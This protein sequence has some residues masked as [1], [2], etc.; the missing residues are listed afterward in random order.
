MHAVRDRPVMVAETGSDGTYSMA[1]NRSGWH[2]MVV[3]GRVGGAP[4]PGEYFG[5]YEG[6]VG[7]AVR[8]K[9]NGAVIADIVASRVMVDDE[10]ASSRPAKAALT[11]GMLRDVVICKSTTWAGKI[12]ISGVVVVG[13]EATLTILPGTTVSFERLDR[14]GDGI[15][16]GEL[17][18]LGR[19]LVRGDAGSPVR[20]T[21][22][23]SRARPSDWSYVLLFAARQKSVVEHA[24]FENAF[25]GLQ[26]HFSSVAIRDSV[27][28]RNV[29]GI[30]FGRARIIIAHNRIAKNRY[31]IR[32]HRIEDRVEIVRNNIQDNRIGIFLV[33]S[34]QNTIDFSAERYIVAAEKR[35]QPVIRHNNISRNSQYNYRLGERFRYDI[36]LAENWWGHTNHVK[37]SQDIFDHADDPSL[38]RVLIRPIL[39]RPSPAAGVRR[40][41]Q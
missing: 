19:L 15:G 20:F 26:A 34:G 32:Q 29:E 8:T 33:P 22:I 6:S 36:L 38:G 5:L 3:R 1:I 21:S 7:H 39:S 27:F 10:E 2:A 31:G 11:S 28:R 18:V 16:D 4:V 13:R 9:K 40:D 24:I 23:S 41:G 37:I 17:R 35:K 12:T 14:N 30:R 25:T